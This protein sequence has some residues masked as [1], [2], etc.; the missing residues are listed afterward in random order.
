MDCSKNNF[1]IEKKRI[2]AVKRFGIAS[3]KKRR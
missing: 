1:Y 2:L 3:G